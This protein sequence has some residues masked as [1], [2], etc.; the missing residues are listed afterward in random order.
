MAYLLLFFSIMDLIEAWLYRYFFLLETPSTKLL[1][2]QKVTVEINIKN[3]TLVKNIIKALCLAVDTRMRLVFSLRKKNNPSLAMWCVHVPLHGCWHGL[4]WTSV[5]DGRW[6]W[7]VGSFVIWRSLTWVY[8]H[9]CVC[10][11]IYTELGCM[12]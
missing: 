4:G 10:I 2:S 5:C 8:W 1:C 11:Q 12:Y 6:W 3:N 7:H 9:V